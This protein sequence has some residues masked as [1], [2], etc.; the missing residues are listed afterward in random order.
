VV[1]YYKAGPKPVLGFDAPTLSVFMNIPAA[2]STTPLG[3]RKV[4][5]D[6]TVARRK[7]TKKIKLALKV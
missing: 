6:V 2:L 5:E 4:F 1:Q 3:K 7:R